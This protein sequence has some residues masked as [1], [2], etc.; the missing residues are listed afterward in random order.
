MRRGPG[1]GDRGPFPHHRHALLVTAVVLVAAGAAG[2]TRVLDDFAGVG[3]WTA[4]PA[5]GVSTALA[6]DAGALRVDVDFHGGGGWAA[7]RRPMPLDLPANYVFSFRVRGELPPNTLEFK[8]VDASGDNVWW[9]T[10]RDFA[11]ASEWQTVTVRRR[12]IAFAW[13]P[14]G[15]G[16]LAHMAALEIA[17]TAGGGG[18]GSVWLDDLTFA[19]LPAARPAT[20]PPL[21]SASASLAGQTPAVAVDG[22]ASTAWR[23][24]AGPAWLQLDLGAP[25]EYGGVVLTWATA[26]TR[27]DYEVQASDDGG[28]WTTARAV[29]GSNGG[30][31]FVALPDGESRFLRVALRDAAAAPGLA[32]VEVMPAA[33]GESA[34]AVYA[35]MARRAPRGRFPRAFIGEQSYWTVVGADGS[36]HEGLLSEDGALEVDKGQLSVEPFVL[37]D[38]RLVAWA[39]VTVTQSLADDYLPIPTVTW[40]HPRLLLEV[41]ALAAGDAAASSLLARYTVRNPG[42]E[43]LRATLFLALRP[44]QVNPPTQFLNGAG[45]VAWVSDVARDEDGV[46]VDRTRRVLVRPAPS[47]FGATTFDE[48]EISE[49]LAAGALPAAAAV[50]DPEGHASAALAF[51]IDIP[52]G[53]RWA[54]ELESPFPGAAPGGRPALAAGRFDEALETARV[55]WREKLN[56][57]TISLPRA[58]KAYEDTLRSTLAYILVNRDGPAIQPGSRAYE[59]SWIRDGSLTSTAL[60]RLGH[61]A[62]VREFIDWFARYQF[63][64][65]KVPCCVDARGADPVAEND[66]N[67]ELLYLLGE[68]RATTHDD[69]FAAAHWDTVERAVDYLD[70]LRRQRRTDA[71]RAPDKQVFFGLLPE[72]ISHEGYSAKPMHSYWDD[73]WALRGLQEAITIAEALGHQAEAA[74]FIAIYDEFR[75]DLYVSIF[76][77]MRQH[78]IDYLPGCAELGDF[79]PTSTTVAV[80][81]GLE[82]SSLS[83][84]PL[85]RTFERYWNESVARRDGTRQWDAYTP[86]ELRTVGVMVQLGWRDRAQAMLDYFMHDRRPAAW[87]QWAEVVDRDPR[88][89][90][91]IG[92][93]PHTW[94][95]SDFIRS[96]LDVLAYERDH[97]QAL[98]VMAGVPRAWIDDPEGIVVSGLRTRWGPLSYRAR[99][100]N[101]VILVDVADGVT[102]P[103]GGVVIDLPLD[104]PPHRVTVDG[105]RAAAKVAPIMIHS[106]PAHV[107][108]RP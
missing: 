9:S 62:E 96:F 34:N 104:R 48:G 24:P 84:E 25:R 20:G 5:E 67:G 7:F 28:S 63:P 101:G 68:Y 37:L 105:H 78:G 2:Q 64:S 95:G 100:E 32:E 106:L 99:S 36:P 30:A 86:Y 82:L 4:A 52:P 87:N 73:F 18:K 72:S 38:G 44:L 16:E 92:D 70:T 27:L 8:L 85:G 93:M 33:F 22:N 107:E 83:P 98:V 46:L 12:N 102:V 42:Q 61:S 29:V 35:E 91:F 69:A 65:G 15:G 59:R 81:P 14:A 77:A 3:A 17:I 97:D 88:H 94:V 13:G 71:Y 26:A 54:A 66:S 40:T 60:L 79:D 103:A 39:D 47:G 89:A 58:G 75:S 76:L 41:T 1:T 31:D 11:F 51:A 90:R 53:G 56:R 55:A 57:V 74:R 6:A 10:R 80:S 43:P 19:E 21:A 108:V 50:H 23:A 45:G 49:R